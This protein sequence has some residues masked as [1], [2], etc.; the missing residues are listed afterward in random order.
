MTE[1]NDVFPRTVILHEFGNIGGVRA[2]RI[3]FR[4]SR[5]AMAAEVRRNPAAVP[6][7]VHGRQHRLPDIACRTQSVQQHE[8]ARTV[9]AAIVLQSAIGRSLTRVCGRGARQ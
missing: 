3:A 2:E 5:S 1:D 9:T 6:M 4:M 7:R 8:K